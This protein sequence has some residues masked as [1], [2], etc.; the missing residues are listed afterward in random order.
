MQRVEK[1]FED[2]LRLFNEYKVRYCIVGAFAFGF[3]AIPR[4][5][6]DL[7][8]LVEPSEKNGEKIVKA[9][10]DFGFGSLNLNISDFTKEG[11]FIQ[12]GYEPVRVDLITS[13]KGVKFNQIW[14]NKKRGMFGS[15][16]A[17]FPGLKEFIKSKQMAGRKQDLADLDILKKFKEK[18]EEKRRKRKKK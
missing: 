4:Y 11:K 16:K 2:L 6:K 14:K 1:D 15:E 5:T 9:L 17:F 12:L 7:D 3:H 8:I 10:K 13:I 18:K